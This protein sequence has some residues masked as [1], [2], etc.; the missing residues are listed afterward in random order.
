MP[1][2]Y[3][4]ELKATW[5]RYIFFF[6]SS[7]FL[8]Y[9]FF[10]NQLVCAQD[11]LGQTSEAQSINKKELCSFTELFWSMYFVPDSVRSTRDKKINDQFVLSG[12]L[13]LG[14]ETQ[15]FSWA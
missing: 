14:E 9:I 1:T 5:I 11:R 15:Q 8:R 13:S 10:I 4:F 7:F 2:Y 6:F 3:D 12:D